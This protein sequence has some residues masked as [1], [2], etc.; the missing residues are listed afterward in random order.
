MRFRVGVLSLFVLIFGAAFA[1][2][3]DIPPPMSAVPPAVAPV[4]VPSLFDPTRWEVR[5]GGFAHGV[6]SV[7]RGTYDVNGELVL[8]QFFAPIG[9]WSYLIPRLHG[10]V[11]Y[12][13]G[14]RTNV[15]YAGL[16]WTIP[17]FD[18]FFV[19]GF[20]DGAVTDGSLT[21]SPTQSALGCNPLFHVGG[22]FGY[23]FDSHWS[24][25]ATFDHDSNG[26]GLGLTNCARNQGLN[27]YGARIG[28]TF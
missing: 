27:N 20:L 6:G 23:R 25:M 1:R 26:S 11:N 8:P 3:A 18:R 7:E 21:G 16:L 28:Y 12:N 17:V 9:W 22:S 2:A 14:G 4:V 19:E 13:T 5:F 15:A 24:V 10:G